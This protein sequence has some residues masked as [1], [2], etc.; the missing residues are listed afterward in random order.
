MHIEIIKYKITCDLNHYK[1]I[2]MCFIY[3]DI[4]LVVVIS[5]T[6]IFSIKLL[7]I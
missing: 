3:V 6:C 1:G 5:N 4:D 7:F 2:Y